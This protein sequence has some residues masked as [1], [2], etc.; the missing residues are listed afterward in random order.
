MNDLLNEFEGNACGIDYKYEEPFL[1][2][3][4]EIDKLNSVT[5]QSSTNWS[6]VKEEAYEI[7]SKHSKDLKLVSWWLYSTWSISKWSGLEE[8]LPS[9]NALI[10][11]FG[12]SLFPK[13]KRVKANSLSWLEQL[14]TNDIITKE[15]KLTTASKAAF[16]EEEF[17]KLEKNYQLISEKEEVFCRK[18]QEQ[19]KLL[20]K[21][22]EEKN[23]KEENPKTVPT[24]AATQEKIL[25]IDSK[26]SLNKSIQ[27][28]KKS[29]T[30]ALPYLY[31]NDLNNIYTIR[32]NRL[33][34][35]LDLEDL[36]AN[37]SGKTPINPPNVNSIDSIN[38]LIN[39][40]KHK[41]ALLQVEN[42]LKFSPFWF[43]G[44]FLSFQILNKMNYPRLALE[45]RAYVLYFATTNEGILDL[46]FN[47]G[48]DFASSKTKNWLALSS[49]SSQEIEENTQEEENSLLVEVNKLIKKRDIKTASSLLQ[50]NYN[51]KTSPLEKFNLRFLHAQTLI[52]A[53]QKDIALVILEEMCETIET[54]S[55]DYWHK[56]LCA[57][58]YLLYLSSYTRQQVDLERLEQIHAKLCKIDLSLA[59]DLKF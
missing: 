24:Q 5:S 50:E 17:A 26:D 41:E 23:K 13:S 28:I 40:D 45:V 31:E 32:L 15:M 56:D 37:N 21:D 55:L 29:S 6:F 30:L 20:K 59:V 35:W 1:A 22:F 38:D 57:K 39:E 48:T 27:N 49:T 9:F 10:E 2:I 53:N 51:K 33:Q 11:K 54:Y 16:F 44:H 43:D 46:K 7:L 12:L 52:E 8:S 47:D 4:A 42:I 3:E 58:V 36:P 25:H 14:L 34:V 19:I 18:I